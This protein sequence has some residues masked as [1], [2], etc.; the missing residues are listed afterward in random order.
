MRIPQCGLQIPNCLLKLYARD[1]T[2]IVFSSILLFFISRIFNIISRSYLP[3]LV[4]VLPMILILVYGYYSFIS[5][6]VLNVFENY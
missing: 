2:S 6:K 3:V 4:L 1:N 5:L